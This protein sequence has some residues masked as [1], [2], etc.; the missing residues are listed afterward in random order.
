MKDS[1][2]ERVK[3]VLNKQI[4]LRTFQK[5]KLFFDLWYQQHCDT[6]VEITDIKYGL[7]SRHLSQR[8]QQHGDCTKPLDNKTFV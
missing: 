8:T 4:F 5:Y 7:L 2:T 3:K 1:Q 6:I